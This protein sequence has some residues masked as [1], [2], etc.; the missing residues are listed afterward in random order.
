[1]AA[2]RVEWATASDL[3]VDGVTFRIAPRERFASTEDLFCVVKRP[4]LVERYMVLL[5]DLRPRRIV[6]LGIFQGGSTALIGLLTRP[7]KLVAVERSP[8]RIVALDQV[9]ERHD[10]AGRV[11]AEYGIDQA[12]TAALLQLID[13]EFDD[14]PLDLVID[15]ASHLVEPTEA[16]FNVLFPRLRAGG[17]YVVEDW[18]WAHFGFGQARPESEPLTTF[19]YEVLNALPTPRGL[20]DE[21]R[22]DKDWAVIRRGSAEVEG[23]YDISRRSNAR[24]RDLVVYLR[25]RSTPS[26]DL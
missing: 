22:L 14:E 18:S 10:L 21:V 4:D 6:E 2:G 13:R 17:L 3:V 15:D 7:E 23:E 11:V 19:V 9:V 1:M 5:E 12:D 20:I 24:V 26:A 25:D 8:E 16:S